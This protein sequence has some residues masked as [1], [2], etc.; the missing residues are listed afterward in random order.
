MGRGSCFSY[1]G[2]FQDRLSIR[3]P[4]VGICGKSFA[5]FCPLL[6]GTCLSFPFW[7]PSSIVFSPQPSSPFFPV[8]SATILPTRQY[9]MRPECH[10]TG[11]KVPV[12]KSYSSSRLQNQ[13]SRFDTLKSHATVEPVTCPNVGPSGQVEDRAEQQT[14]E[15]RVAPERHPLPCIV[16][17]FFLAFFGRFNS[18]TAAELSPWGTSVTGYALS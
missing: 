10:D 1:A 13:R 16:L 6:Y 18:A 8:I 12:G 17:P 3:R 9:S 5:A 11:Y 7:N 15:T 4:V 2:A 14:V